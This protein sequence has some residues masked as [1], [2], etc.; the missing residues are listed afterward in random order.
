MNAQYYLINNIHL[1]QLPN[2]SE[3]ILFHIKQNFLHSLC[4]LLI[5]IKK[6]YE[7]KTTTIKLLLQIFELTM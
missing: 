5:D 7:K 2:Q 3:Q 1:P 6:P 4:L